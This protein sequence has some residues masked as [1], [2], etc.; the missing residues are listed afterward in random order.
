MWGCDA[1]PIFIFFSIAIC[2]LVAIG[3]LRYIMNILFSILLQLYI[4]RILIFVIPVPFFSPLKQGVIY[5][6]IC[7]VNQCLLSTAS[8][9]FCL[10]CAFIFKQKEGKMNTRRK[11]IQPKPSKP[12]TH[13]HLMR[14][15]YHVLFQVKFH[16]HVEYWYNMCA[17][18]VQ[19]DLFRQIC[20]EVFLQDPN[21]P[22]PVFTTKFQEVLKKGG[23]ETM[24]KNYGCTLN[25]TG[26]Q[27]ARLW[28]L[29]TSAQRP[30][31]NFRDVFTGC[32]TVF[33]IMSVMHK[34]YVSPEP[35]DY[36][37]NKLFYHL[38]ADWS[39]LKDRKLMQEWAVRKEK[40]VVSTNIIK[41]IEL[42]RPEGRFTKP[43]SQFDGVNVLSG[44]GL[45]HLPPDVAIA[46]LKA[47]RDANQESQQY[48][49]DPSG[50][51]V[52][53]AGVQ[54]KAGSSNMNDGYNILEGVTS[55]PMAEW[56][57]K[58]CD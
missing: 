11:F 27:K 38:K 49:T 55:E 29:K 37:S 32:Q 12:S 9:C 13:W 17:T 31:D 22:E 26:K 41:S 36:P 45:G 15:P 28:I 25:E 53:R 47:R 10:F 48:Y 8:N 52:Y 1:L 40:E 34:D 14:E 24:I 20:K 6:N 18:G 21:E 3:A 5:L 42:P 16:E 2:F 56:K 30:L 33:Q 4:K 51:T 44:L 46:Q 58:V 23:A 35:E 43:K 50:T 39:S 19:R 7:I 54:R 57:V